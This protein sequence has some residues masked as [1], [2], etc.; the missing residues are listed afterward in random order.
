MPVTVK[1]CTPCAG[2]VVGAADAV[3]LVGAEHRELYARARL[4]MPARGNP[5]VHRDLERRLRSPA[6]DDCR[7]LEVGVAS[8]RDHA[9]GDAS[10][11]D[12]TVGLDV[13][14]RDERGGRARLDARMLGNQLLDRTECRGVLDE[15]REVGLVVVVDEPVEGVRSPPCARDAGQREA[16]GEAA[17]DREHQRRP[18]PGAQL[19]T[20]QEPPRCHRLH[21]TNRASRST[22]GSHDPTGGA[23]TLMSRCR[24][25]RGDS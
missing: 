7:P 22:H 19:R 2:G 24:S 11:S 4:E 5:V 8:D 10:P 15:H 21:G 16:E 25:R 14:E 13:A 6:P 17:R 1:S 12:R 23:G 20:R 9:G 18:Q 3:D